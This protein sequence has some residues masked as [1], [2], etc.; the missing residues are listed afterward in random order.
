MGFNG[1]S[2]NNLMWTFR[3]AAKGSGRR[4]GALREVWKQAISQRSNEG[5]NLLRWHNIGIFRVHVA[6]ADRVT[7]LAAVE[8]CVFNDSDADVITK[9]IDDS[10]ANA[11][12]CS[13][14]GNDQAI[15]AEQRQVTYQI[16]SKK[17]AWRAVYLRYPVF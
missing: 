12:A 2:A 6:E 8:A 3:K 9:R 1:R 11:A 15:G 7:G 17:D 10:G 16:A 14:P 5:P 13:A 4:L